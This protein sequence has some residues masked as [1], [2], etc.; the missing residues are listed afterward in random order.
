MWGETKAH[1]GNPHRLREDM[2]TAQREPQHAYWG[3]CQPLLHCAASQPDNTCSTTGCKH[4]CY[5]SA[6]VCI[7]LIVQQFS[8]NAFSVSVF[9]FSVQ[10]SA[11][12]NSNDFSARRFCV[13]ATRMPCSRWYSPGCVN[14]MT[15]QLDLAQPAHIWAT[16]LLGNDGPSKFSG[17][18][19]VEKE[20]STNF[21][22]WMSKT[23]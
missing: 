5:S 18:M 10:P 11:A 1:R 8:W 23:L 22:D 19:K 4:V 16:G 2:K 7:E 13:S 6:G 3:Q 21:H 15:P 9:F 20:Y 12:R 17:G 14:L